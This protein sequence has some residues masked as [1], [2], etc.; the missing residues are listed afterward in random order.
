LHSLLIELI[1]VRILLAIF[2]DHMTRGLASVIANHGEQSVE[3]IIIRLKL[4][5]NIQQS[6]NENVSVTRA[7]TT[8]A[9]RGH[10]THSSGIHP[11]PSTNVSIPTWDASTAEPKTPGVPWCYQKNLRHHGTPR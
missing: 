6:E 9:R 8:G 11:T 4:Q 7:T 1:N 2:E 5:L 10:S 3:E